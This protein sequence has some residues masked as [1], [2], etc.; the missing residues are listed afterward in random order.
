MKHVIARTKST[1]QRRIFRYAL[2]AS[3]SLGVLM[4][5]APSHAATPDKIRAQAAAPVAKFPAPQADSTPAARTREL[6]RQKVAPKK[7]STAELEARARKR[8]TGDQD[9]PFHKQSRNVR[10]KAKCPKIELI[11]YEGSVIPYNRPIE[12]N[13][14]FK[15]RLVRFERLVAE[16]A[17]E[18]YGRAP[19]RIIHVGGYS[20]KTISGRGKTLSEH[21]YGHAIDVKGF[22]FEAVED[23]DPNAGVDPIDQAFK[24]DLKKHWNA[25]KGLGAKH[26]QFL[27]ALAEALKD[28]GPFSLML[29]P[30]Y[31]G[32]DRLFHFDFGPQFFFRI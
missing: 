3:M 10:G 27:H 5:C 32:H 31:R 11:K 6:T 28:R 7:R 15:E 8:E 16:V 20:C 18:V 30:A 25:K 24:V 4:A 2:A 13:T 21:V 9:Y 12:I 19:S 17:V 14:Y 22:E 23:G 29:G 26:R 1:T